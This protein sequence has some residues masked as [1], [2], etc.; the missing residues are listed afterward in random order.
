[1]TFRPYH[2]FK[3]QSFTPLRD[4]VVEQIKQWRMKE[5]RKQPTSKTK[6]KRKNG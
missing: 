3:K 6:G 1:M 5:K 2:R 4:T